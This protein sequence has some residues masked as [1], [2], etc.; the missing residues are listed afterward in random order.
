MSN[1]KFSIIIPIYNTEAYLAR[2][3]DSV[4]GQSHTNLEVILI[5]DGSEDG[6]PR[7]C[8]E[9][10][11]KDSRVSVIHKENGGVSIAR[12]IGLQKAIGDYVMFVDSDDF[13]DEKSCE[14]FNRLILSVPDVEVVASNTKMIVNDSFYYLKNSVINGKSVVS[15]YEYLK[16]Q[17]INGKLTTNIGDKIYK[18]SFI[19][20]NVFFFKE[21]LRHAEDEHW[22]MRALLLAKKVIILD[23]VHYNYVVRHGSATQSDFQQEHITDMIDAYKDLE[24]IYCDIHDA[25]LKELLL[26]KLV[27]N[28]FYVFNKGKLYKREYRELVSREFCN[29][30]PSTLRNKLKVLIFKTNKTLFYFV[31]NFAKVLR[32][33]FVYKVQ[34]KN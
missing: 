14:S 5:N 10:A 21:G 26:N 34:V 12:N 32:A 2:C 3:I 17:L 19:N 1:I 16:E 7:I 25:E 28:F 29:L 9:Y 11:K 20:D 24:S 13:I 33:K 22:C 15:G 18:R 8:D 4:L 30:K 31:F 23:F 6:S 27:N